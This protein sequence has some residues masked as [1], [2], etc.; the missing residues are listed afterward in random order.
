MGVHSTRGGVRQVIAGVLDCL[1]PALLSGSLKKEGRGADASSS[2]SVAMLQAKPRLRKQAN[3]SFAW[4]PVSGISQA[5]KE[6]PKVLSLKGHFRGTLLGGTLHQRGWQALFG[7]W[8][9][10]TCL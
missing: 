3:H 5:L 8:A 6:I 4:F 9:L 10:W 2:C 7:P 1:L